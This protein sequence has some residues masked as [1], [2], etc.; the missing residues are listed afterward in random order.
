[1]KKNHNNSCFCCLSLELRLPFGRE[2]G[3]D[4]P[5][6]CPDDL[7]TGVR[8]QQHVS[9]SADFITESLRD[10]VVRRSGLDLVTDEMTADL[11]ME[12]EVRSFD[13]GP[14]DL[15]EGGGTARYQIK[16]ICGLPLIDNRETR[17]LYEQK[18]LS[19]KDV[20]ADR[21]G[22]FFS[23]ENDTLKRISKQMSL[24]LLSLIFVEFLMQGP[25]PF[26]FSTAEAANCRRKRSCCCRDI[27]S[28]WGVDHRLGGETVSRRS[29]S[30]QPFPLLSGQ[31]GIRL[32]NEVLAE[33]GSAS[34]LRPGPQ[35]S[36]AH[37]A[38]KSKAV[39]NADEIKPSDSVPG[40][41][42]PDTLSLSTS[43]WNFHP[44]ISNCSESRSWIPWPKSLP[45]C[46]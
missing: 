35:G 34:I 32:W 44:M 28:S 13:V 42:N 9:R 8:K 39:P 36:G 20:L 1:M 4:Y 38:D 24:G 18:G 7:R 12:G 17:L 25:L 37:S 29:H 40:K 3:V 45:L 23:M 26:V 14:V 43:L 2:G 5:R 6:R 11:V 33:A 46:L 30:V 10:G 31:R 16:V 15:F 22:N 21:S 19:Y 27:T 41:A